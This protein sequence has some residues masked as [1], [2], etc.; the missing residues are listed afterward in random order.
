MLRIRITL[1]SED[2]RTLGMEYAR[3]A[4]DLAATGTQLEL[5]SCHY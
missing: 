4:L 5:T 3:Q 1:G 2:P